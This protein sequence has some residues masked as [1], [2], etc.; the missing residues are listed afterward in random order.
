MTNFWPVETPQTLA[1]VIALRKRLKLSQR[2]FAES[3]D[4][5]LRTWQDIELG[6]GP[7][8]KLHLYAICW[9]YVS[10]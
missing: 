3:L 7:F 4:M 6:V 9:V 5:P 1:D 10:G 2:E 8:R